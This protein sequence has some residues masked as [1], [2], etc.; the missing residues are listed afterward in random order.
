[1]K[2][3]SFAPAILSFLCASSI[4]ALGNEAAIATI[5]LKESPF[6]IRKIPGGD[7]EI[8]ADD[9][10][11]LARP[12]EKPRRIHR[13]RPFWMGETEVTW[14]QFNAFLHE[15]LSNPELN[16]IPAPLGVPN[17]ELFAVQQH[18]SG[19]AENEPVYGI[20]P[21]AAMAYCR[22]LSGRTGR[23]FRLPTE[24]E[25]EHAM[26]LGLPNN[27]RGLSA[28]EYRRI[29]DDQA[30]LVP[31]RDQEKLAVSGWP[32]APVGSKKPNRVGLF[33]MEGNVS[34]WM[35]NEYTWR[36]PS[37]AGNSGTFFAAIRSPRE[38]TNWVARGGHLCAS[39]A[40]LRP[41][42]R[43]VPKQAL[44][45]SQ[46]DGFG[47]LTGPHADHYPVGFRVACSEDPEE[48]APG[49]AEY[50]RTD[51]TPSAYEWIYTGRAASSGSGLYW[52][53]WARQ[54]ERFETEIPAK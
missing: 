30:V 21:W 52:R 26:R 31:K 14:K 25:W 1:M 2:T 15:R 50:W 34:E 13:V 3:Y 17:V 40:D 37:K 24:M 12:D 11:A 18:L 33:D 19:K 16:H 22:W 38:L 39:A 28:D 23:N 32:L 35:L 41:S 20:A 48:D 8:G 51:L 5:E 36:Y 27:G 10:D 7:T 44:W 53:H 42:A 49:I 47:W 29:L 54:A 4:S 9:G 6:R 46:V 43:L 45:L